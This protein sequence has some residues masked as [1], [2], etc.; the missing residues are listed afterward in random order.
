MTAAP[1]LAPLP[2]A[3]RVLAAVPLADRTELAVFSRLRHWLGADFQLLVRPAAR[4]L[5]SLHAAIPDARPFAARQ[6]C[7]LPAAWRLR[8]LMRDW[9]PDVFFTPHNHTLAVGLMASAGLPVKVIGYRGTVGH[10]ARYDPASWMTYLHPRLAHIQCVSDAV[11]RYLRDDVGIDASKLTRIYKGHD[12]AWY[13]AI[14][15][16]PLDLGRFGVP[17]G[18]TLIGFAGNA[19]PVKGVDYLLAALPHLPPRVHLLLIGE[20]GDARTRRVLHR[21]P[22]AARIHVTG[23]RDDAP[24]LMRRCDVLVMPS[25]AREGLPRAVVEAMAMGKPVVA[26]TV[27]GL[28]ELVEN[29]VSGLLVPPRDP[30]ALAAAIRRLLDDPALAHRLG[31]AARARIISH[32]HI[33]V[34]ARSLLALFAR[35]AGVPPPTGD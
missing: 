24:A 19:R 28:P 30:A 15:A 12:P 23:W 9:R 16:S 26:T 11:L 29:E 35:V 6:R 17:S 31:A 1:S 20:P 13:D 21:A 7:D 32:F 3:L 2:H 5:D 10:I 25:V 33:D 4:G 27:G 18:A 8:R 34:T 22:C 14:P